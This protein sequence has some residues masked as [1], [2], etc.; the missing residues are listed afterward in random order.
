MLG[1]SMDK[2]VLAVLKFF[3]I[4]IILAMAFALFTAFDAGMWPKTAKG[5]L[6]L[7]VFAFPAYLFS[8][9]LGEKVFSDRIS[10]MLE[11]EQKLISIKRMSYV[12]LILLLAFGLS[13]FLYYLAK[14]YLGDIF[15]FR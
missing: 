9:Y 1:V 6:L 14:L 13:V 7:A 10:G 12:L 3:A 15:N 4:Y 2:K 5:W 8:E 11:K